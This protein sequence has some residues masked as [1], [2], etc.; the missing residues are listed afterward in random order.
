VFL[1]QLM[2][3]LFS[4]S[5][6][7]SAI[8]AALICLAIVLSSALHSESPAVVILYAY[9]PT[10]LLIEHTGDFVGCARM[11]EPFFYGVPLWVLV[12]SVAASLAVIGIKRM[13]KLNGDVGN[14]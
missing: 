11:I 2:K 10:I 12:Y 14:G 3:R 7:A 8:Q 4:Y 6:L 1:S 9:L 5:V 13:N